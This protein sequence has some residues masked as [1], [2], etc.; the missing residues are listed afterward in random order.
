MFY[1]YSGAANVN[2]DVSIS[3]D[4]FV[5]AIFLAYIESCVP[6]ENAIESERQERI[7]TLLYLVSYLNALAKPGD[8]ADIGLAVRDLTQVLNDIT[9]GT[10]KDV[11]DFRSDN[12]LYKQLIMLGS[13]TLLANSEA[14]EL[15]M[16]LLNMRNTQKDTISNSMAN[17]IMGVLSAALRTDIRLFIA[18]EVGHR[19]EV[20]VY[21]RCDNI[22]SVALLI[23]RPRVLVLYDRKL[24]QRHFAHL[25]RP[26]EYK[27]GFLNS[28]VNHALVPSKENSLPDCFYEVM[29]LPEPY[30]GMEVVD[31]LNCAIS[32]ASSGLTLA[33]DLIK[34]S[35]Y[36][37]SLKILGERLDQARKTAPSLFVQ[38]RNPVS[39]PSAKTATS[40]S[41]GQ[42]KPAPAEVPQKDIRLGGQKQPLSSAGDTDS[43]ENGQPQTQNETKKK[44][45]A[46]CGKPIAPGQQTYVDDDTQKEVHDKCY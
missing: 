3:V 41:E 44:I 42:M 25:L 29:G 24:C 32:A 33:D 22:G 12:L 40:P 35:D 5:Y 17:K 26:R 4:T 15:R 7:K 6:D 10:R 36:K 13:A 14:T 23:A 1:N 21:D 28:W 19:L 11:N 31:G 46:R 30:S 18:S 20:S 27:L 39:K 43:P 2:G 16:E 38:T 9:N 45:C 34:G 8:D 37:S